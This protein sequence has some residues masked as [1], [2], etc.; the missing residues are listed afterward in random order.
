[1][2]TDKALVELGGRPL[3]EHAM[4][5]LRGAGLPVHIAG[6]GDAVRARLESNTRIIPDAE[7]GCGPL[8]GVCAALRS[9]TARYAVFLPVDV[10]LVPISLVLYL[11]RHARTAASPVTVASLNASPQTFP[12]VIAREALQVLEEKLRDGELR[13]LAAFEAAAVQLGRR[14]SVLP[15]EVLVQCGQVAH[16]EAIPAIR[17]FLNINTAQDLRRAS[18]VRTSRVS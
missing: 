2:G 14:I 7:T 6:A 15:V 1:M 10:P 4:G 18:S 13:C 11:L 5:I 9:S 8:A 16:P 17:W 12:A 3:I